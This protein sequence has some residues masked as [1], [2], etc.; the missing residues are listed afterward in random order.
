MSQEEIKQNLVEKLAKIE[1]HMAKIKA[2]K[3]QV[4]VAMDAVKKMGD[5]EAT[6][7]EFE[8]TSNE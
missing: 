8:E 1:A 3:N 5:D 2:N 6:L 7:K 4:D